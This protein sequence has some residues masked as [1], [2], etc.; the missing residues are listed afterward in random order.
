M[1]G[2]ERDRPDQHCQPSEHQRHGGH[3]SSPFA[4]LAHAPTSQ[5]PEHDRRDSTD[6][7]RARRSRRADQRGNGQPTGSRRRWSGRMCGQP[8]EGADRQVARKSHHLGE[9]VRGQYL[10]DSQLKFVLAEPAV[11][12]RCLQ[13]ADC[14]IALSAKL[15]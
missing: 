7:R 9:Q 1:P 6:P 4:G 8:P 2:E 10:S 3:G 5:V 13:N 12:K 15:S 14:A 11:Q